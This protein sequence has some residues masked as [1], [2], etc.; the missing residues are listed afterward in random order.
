MNGL[1]VITGPTAVG[2]SELGVIMAQR[3]GGEIVSAD[4]MQ[5][6]RGM[7]I[8][9][10]AP[11]PEEMRGI[12]HHLI[13]TVDPSEAYSAARYV[14]EASACVDDIMARGK[15]PIIV[16]GTGLYIDSLLSGRS[17]P[18]GDPELRSRFSAQYD[19]LGGEK[20]L[21]M[22][23]EADPESAARLAANDKKRI[24]RALEVY[25]STGRTVTQ[26]NRETALLPPR[27][28]YCRIALDYADRSMLYARIDARVDEMLRQGLADEVRELLERGLSENSTAM[29]AIGY[30]EL[31]PALRGECSDAEA[32]E[33]IKR[34]SRR[35]AKRQLSWLRSRSD[36]E[37]I[38]WEKN[39]DYAKAALISTQFLEEKGIL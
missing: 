12:P 34:E 1:L 7:R 28:H 26:H 10:A 9:T 2:K 30:K 32:A 15:L 4:S 14:E 33:L 19:E 37:W 38:I 35:Y 36:V 24:V 27:Y 13:G 25:Y 3:L 5:I 20:M 8:G 29:Q 31:I 16:G 17:F 18:G 39:R 6:Y 23:A 21:S 11:T 22:L